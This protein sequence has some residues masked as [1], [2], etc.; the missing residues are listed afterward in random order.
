MAIPEEIRKKMEEVL[1][2]TIGEYRCFDE[3]VPPCK[4]YRVIYSYLKKNFSDEIFDLISMYNELTILHYLCIAKDERERIE[5]WI[6]KRY[7][8]VWDYLRGRISWRLE[9]E[10]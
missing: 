5:K 2:Y 4:L 6:E 9:Y 1:N 8:D 10:I 7:Y 3:A